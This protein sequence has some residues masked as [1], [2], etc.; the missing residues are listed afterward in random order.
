MFMIR[1]PTIVWVIMQAPILG[2]QLFRFQVVK[3]AEGLA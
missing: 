3:I 2:I 1:N